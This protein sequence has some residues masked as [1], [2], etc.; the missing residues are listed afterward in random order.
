MS[1][2]RGSGGIFISYRRE[3]TAANAGRLYDRLSGRFGEDRVFMDVDSIAYGV[4]FTRAVVDAVSG[5]DVLLVLIGRDWLA[6]TDGK[7]RR[8][9][10]NSDDW[11]RVEIETALQRDIRVV[12]MLVD[13]A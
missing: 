8:R 10:D 7:G 4:D 12:P 5:C 2:L 11:V 1:S 6:I 9:L 13:G 3:E